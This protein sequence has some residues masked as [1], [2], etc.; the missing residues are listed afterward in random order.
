MED[1]TQKVDKRG[2]PV[3]EQEEWKFDRVKHFGGPED[4][5]IA[6]ST[7]D[8]TTTIEIAIPNG[9]TAFPLRIGPN[10]TLAHAV[11]FG[12]PEQGVISIYEPCTLFQLTAE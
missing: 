1:G 12:M 11:Y 10:H 6:C 4:V 9:R 7:V 5:A 2:K 3:F 8:G